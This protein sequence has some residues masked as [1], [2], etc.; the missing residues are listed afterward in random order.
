MDQKPAMMRDKLDQ[1]LEQQES[2]NSSRSFLSSTVPDAIFSRVRSNLGPQI[3]P[4]PGFNSSKRGRTKRAGYACLYFRAAGPKEPGRIV[5][6]RGGLENRVL[7]PFRLRK[8]EARL[9]D[10]LCIDS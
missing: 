3:F 2:R 9:D 8:R 6:G 4:K 1:I 7:Q 5:Q 10:S